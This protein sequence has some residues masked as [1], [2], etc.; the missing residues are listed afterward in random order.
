M[1]QPELAVG[2]MV[3]VINSCLGTDGMIGEIVAGP[4]V[5]GI[6]LPMWEVKFPRPVKAYIGSMGV[7]MSD[8]VWYEPEKLRPVSGLPDDSD[9]TSDMEY[10]RRR[11]ELVLKYNVKPLG[12]EKV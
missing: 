7:R 4:T 8:R 1:D 11:E 12:K 9:T 6:K 3:I 5:F 2:V 10:Q